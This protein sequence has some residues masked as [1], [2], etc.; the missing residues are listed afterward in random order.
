MYY[1]PPRGKHYSWLKCAIL[2]ISTLTLIICT[3]ASA[4]ELIK[5]KST[6]EFIDLHSGPGRGYPVFHVIEKGEIVSLI[7]SKTSWIKARTEDG[8]EGWIYR[9]NMANTIGINGEEVRLGIPSR[10]DYSNRRW[11]VGFGIGQFS[12]IPSLG[13]HGGYRFTNNLMLELQFTQATGNQS[14]NELLSIGLVHQPFPE[15]RFSPYFTLA[16]GSIKTTAS[17]QSI[18]PN[19][20]ND[21]LFLVGLGGYYYISQR[22]MAKLELNQYTSLPSEDFNNEINEVKLGFSAFF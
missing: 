16:S 8:I 10:E 4:K 15:W 14:V 1:S 9:G 22:F 19:D 20:G 12:S 21:E 11:E 5:I 7:K 13:I 3:N 6:A 18:A 2:L 17:S